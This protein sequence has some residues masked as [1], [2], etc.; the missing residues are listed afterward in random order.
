MP[1]PPFQY[2]PAPLDGLRAAAGAGERLAGALVR[3]IRTRQPWFQ[4]TDWRRSTAVLRPQAWP[5]PTPQDAGDTLPPVL[6]CSA[7]PWSFRFQRPQQLALALGRRGHPVLFIEGFQRSRLLPARRQSTAGPNLQVLQ[8]RVPGRPDLYRQALSEQSALVVAERIGAG[9][10]RPP[11]MVLVQL[12]IWARVGEELRR[13]FGAALVYDRIDLHSG[14]AGVPPQMDRLEESL[15]RSADLVTASSVDLL[16]RSRG[17][18]D[19]VRLLRNAVALDDFPLAVRARQAV[20][21]FGYVGA[22]GPWFDVEAIRAAARE[23]SG[24]EF[25]IAGQVED[26]EVAGLAELPNLRLLGEIP[27][28]RVPEF[29]AGLDVSL[30]PFR[31]TALT[32]AVDPVKLYE[33]LATGLPVVARDLPALER[34]RE[35]GL[36][37]YREPGELAGRLAEALEQDTPALARARRALVETETWDERAGALLAEVAAT[38]GA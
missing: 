12:P 17:H 9:L 16:E 37:R 8:V 33:A 19:R 30:I 6:F 14:F 18:C 21:R 1:E 32:V 29:L 38:G 34:W 3:R 24:A 2:P 27:Y 36:Y 7:L 25:V 15:L 4:S 26:P 11:M 5:A 28:R 13:W 20:P 35:P 10:R 22:L 23:H 31:R